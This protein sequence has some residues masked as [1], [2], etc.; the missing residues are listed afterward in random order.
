MPV[1]DWSRVDAGVFHA[2]HMGWNWQLQEALNAGRL[3]ADYYSLVEQQTIEDNED[4]A[5]RI[6]DLLTLHAGPS[7]NSLPPLPPPQGGLALAEAPPKVRHRATLDPDYRLRRRTLA[8]RHV[9]GHRLVAVIEIVSPANKDRVRHVEQ[10]VS[11]VIAFLEAGVH[12][13]L[14][15]LFPPGSCDPRG[16]HGAMGHWVDVAGGA[17]QRSADE[18]LTLASYRAVEPP[19]AFFEHLAIGQR[20][21]DMPLFFDPGRYVNVPLEA[22]YEV[23]FAA[24]PRFWR[25]KLIV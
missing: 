19:D 4:A 11:K 1:N 24:M 12:V 2:F 14:I 15:D 25:D 18:S 22:T 10:F 7:P 16:M 20:I 13:L 6:T 5:R 3:P 21:P 9:S 23:A 8:I 17:S